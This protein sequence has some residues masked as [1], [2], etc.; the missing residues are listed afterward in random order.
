M[1]GQGAVQSVNIQSQINNALAELK[2]IDAQREEDVNLLME[3]RFVVPTQ[4]VSVVLECCLRE[5][6]REETEQRLLQTL[7]HCEPQRCHTQSLVVNEDPLTW[8]RAGIPD[9]VARVVMEGAEDLAPRPPTMRTPSHTPFTERKSPPRE[10]LG[11]SASPMARRISSAANAERTDT[12]LSL[13]PTRPSTAI[14]PST[15]STAGRSTFTPHT[16]RMT[17]GGDERMPYGFEHRE[18]VETVRRPLTA[19]IVNR[20]PTTAG[21]RTD[22]RRPLTARTRTSSKDDSPPSKRQAFSNSSAA[23]TSAAPAPRAVVRAGVLAGIEISATDGQA[24]TTSL[25]EMAQTVAFASATQRQLWLFRAVE[26]FWNAVAAVKENPEVSA[27]LAMTAGAAADG[28]VAPNS[29][30]MA[31]WLPRGKTLFRPDTL[32]DYL[33]P[34]PAPEITPRFFASAQDDKVSP[35]SYPATT[36]PRVT[37]QR[38][39]QQLTLDPHSEMAHDGPPTVGTDQ[40]TSPEAAFGTRRASRKVARIRVPNEPSTAGS[41]KSVSWTPVA[42]AAVNAASIWGGLNKRRGSRF[43]KQLSTRQMSMS[44]RQMSAHQ[45]QT[46]FAHKDASSPGFRKRL[47]AS[48]AR[49]DSLQPFS[50]GGAP[51]HATPKNMWSKSILN[52]VPKSPAPEASARRALKRFTSTYAPSRSP[53]TP[54]KAVM[55]PSPRSLMSAAIPQKAAHQL[56]RTFLGHVLALVKLRQKQEELLE[57]EPDPKRSP[58]PGPSVS[59]LD[60]VREEIS[61]EDRRKARLQEILEEVVEEAADSRRVFLVK[62]FLIRTA[63]WR[64]AQKAQ[65]QLERDLFV[66][67]QLVMRVRRFRAAKAKK[68]RNTL[69]EKLAANREDETVVREIERFDAAMKIQRVLQGHFARKMV[70]SYT[71]AILSIQKNYRRYKSNKR[72]AWVRA[73]RAMREETRRET[74]WSQTRAELQSTIAGER[75]LLTKF[76]QVERHV[77]SLKTTLE[78]AAAVTETKTSAWRTRAERIMVA[79]KLSAEWIPQCSR[80]GGRKYYLNVVTG[81][82]Q[83]ENPNLE[84]VKAI[85]DVKVAEDK[86]KLEEQA[87]QLRVQ[88]DEAKDHERALKMEVASLLRKGE[89]VVLESPSVSNS[90]ASSPSFSPGKSTRRAPSI[91]VL[92]KTKLRASLKSA[93]SFRV[94]PPPIKSSSPGKAC[95][96]RPPPLRADSLKFPTP[97]DAPGGGHKAPVKVQL[98]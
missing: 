10:R 76:A 9:D 74:R 40:S 45:R 44:Q 68:L 37:S 57:V 79:K 67:N 11:P 59:S 73:M 64:R 69:N 70:K 19:R 51:T 97:P 8:D 77:N 48:S 55:L 53:K 12:Q 75:D 96:R 47:T 5:E 36:P 27:L 98:A 28:S 13:Q 41:N 86:K 50:R 58:S 23:V 72:A 52:L 20:R 2:G 94:R 56:P 32:D 89:A 83:E 18:C 15:A 22:Q 78:N 38:Q 82:S 26:R 49:R 30:L 4:A 33:R 31:Q 93:N 1:L 7:A 54:A 25:K 81:L 90:Q 46:S 62:N 43:S 3:S 88:L 61:A 6:W 85:F 92:A 16:D 29:L 63:L 71:H 66:K 80:V 14:R 17:H 95:S 91:A 35:R 87:A 34:K 42:S 24:W 39:P 60:N 21:R 84:A 65:A